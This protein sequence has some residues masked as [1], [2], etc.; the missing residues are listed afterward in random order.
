M[1]LL[2]VMFCTTVFCFILGEDWIK[3]PKL[4]T[5]EEVVHPWNLCCPC[6]CAAGHKLC[7]SHPTAV[8]DGGLWCFPVLR[9]LWE[10]CFPSMYFPKGTWG[11]THRFCRCWCRCGCWELSEL[12]PGH[13]PLAPPRGNASSLRERFCFHWIYIFS[14]FL[15]VAICI[16]PIAGKG[17]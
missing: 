2:M 17:L 10:Q 5:G 15:L 3:W 9:V 13:A 1:G 12:Y 11:L 6:W 4:Q 16:N 8:S 14:P 7:P